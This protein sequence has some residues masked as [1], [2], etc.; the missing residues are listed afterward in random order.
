MSICVDHGGRQSLLLAQ[1]EGLGRTCHTGADRGPAATGRATSGRFVSCFPPICPIQGTAALRNGSCAVPPTEVVPSWRASRGRILDNYQEEAGMSRFGTDWLLRHHRKGVGAFL[2][3]AIAALPS[4]S[5]GE[6]DD[7]G[8]EISPSHSDQVVQAD[9][10]PHVL[11]TPPDPRPAFLLTL[12]HQAS[13]A[14]LTPPVPRPAFLAAL[15][16]IISVPTSA[17]HQVRSYVEE[18]APTREIISRAGV[19]GVTGAVLFDLTNGTLLDAHARHISLPPAS[20]IKI[21]TGA[22][23]LE[24][25]GPRHRFETRVLTTGPVV[26]GRVQGDLILQGGGDPALDNRA[27]AA[28]VDAL[29]QSGIRR[30]EGGYYFDDTALPRGSWIDAGQ[31]D[32]AASSTGYGALNLN[33][34]RVLMEAVSIDKDRTEVR[35][36]ADADEIEVPI[37]HITVSVAMSDDT[38][39]NGLLRHR[40]VDGGESWIIDY[41]SLRDTPERW[42]PVRN[43]GLYSASVFR[44]LARER[45]LLLP[46]PQRVSSTVTGTT[47][48]VHRSRP[49]AEIVSGMLDFSN[50]L[51]AEV[52]GLYTATQSGVSVDG[53]RD[54]ARRMAI[55]IGSEF[56][57][58]NRL[59]DYSGLGDLARITPSAFQS[60]LA[61]SVA[62]SDTSDADIRSILP[63]R[64]IASSESG[65]SLPPALI[66]AKTGSLYYVRGLV[67]YIRLGDGTERE[68]G[69]AVFSA[70]LQKRRRLTVG[71]YDSAPPLEVEDAR[72]WR[73]EAVELESEILRNWLQAL[74]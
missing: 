38:A 52:I 41:R 8:P 23:A 73:R 63:V 29:L 65:D 1:V 4:M 2:F 44:H 69:F 59:V 10:I 3:A 32:G 57:R 39:T 18:P 28:M 58:Y 51:T 64:S 24:T 37:E 35:L 42:L 36:T 70:D 33:Y 48:A 43:P 5:A 13:L 53:L 45:G 17:P 47:L 67:G 9:A 20:T 46:S 6:S 30:I 25:L 11:W 72:Q 50:N 21:V 34:N 62:L 55:W 56:A 61:R 40:F 49:L 7:L 31:R 22:W 12:E 66:Q 15:A 60:I 14:A 68:F 19:S 74:S 16:E 26:D 54:G 71:H 27:L